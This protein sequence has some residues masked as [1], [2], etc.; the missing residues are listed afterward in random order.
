MLRYPPPERPVVF[1]LAASQKGHILSPKINHPRWFTCFLCEKESKMSIPVGDK[2]WYFRT[3]QI[4]GCLEHLMGSGSISLAMRCGHL[5]R[6][7]EPS[8][9]CVRHPTWRSEL[10]GRLLTCIYRNLE[11]REMYCGGLLL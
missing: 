6:S 10:A 3:V 5:L 2:K 9:A 8:S 11:E 4:V 1:S 7:P